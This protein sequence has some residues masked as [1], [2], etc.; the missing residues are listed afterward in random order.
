MDLTHVKL[1]IYSCEVWSIWLIH[2]PHL[3]NSYFYIICSFTILSSFFVLS[4]I[5]SSLILD[6]VWLNLNGLWYE[7]GIWNANEQTLQLQDCAFS[8]SLLHNQM[9]PNPTKQFIKFKICIFVRLEIAVNEV[10]LDEKHVRSVLF[11]F[12]L[13]IEPFKKPLQ[14]LRLTDLF[15]KGVS[16]FKIYLILKGWIYTVNNI[17]YLNNHWRDIQIG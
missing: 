4:N 7:I 12:K 16:E 2:Y 3:F 1:C 8:L 13:I 10:K 9:C 15:F 17:C 6:T 11:C 5:V 14:I